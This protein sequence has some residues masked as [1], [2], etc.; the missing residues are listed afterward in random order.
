MEAVLN[1]LSSPTVR[2]RIRELEQQQAEIQRDLKALRS[3]VDKT[4]VPEH[5]LRELLTQVITS[6][7]EDNSLILSIVYRVEVSSDSLTIWTILDADP[8]GHI[9]HTSEGVTITPGVASGVPTVFVTPQFL[10]IVVAR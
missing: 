10:R 5:R 9:P 1:G 4:A 6:A 7:T 2:N 3:S 8:D